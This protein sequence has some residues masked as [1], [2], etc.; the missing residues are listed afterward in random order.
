MGFVRSP[1]CNLDLHQISASTHT[2]HDT[3][4]TRSVRL[5]WD[6]PDMSVRSMVWLGHGVLKEREREALDED[7]D[8]TVAKDGRRVGEVIR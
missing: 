4:Y 1:D 7:W 5:G 2:T 3:K 6:Q 8:A